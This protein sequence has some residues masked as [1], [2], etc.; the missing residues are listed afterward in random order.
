MHWLVLVADGVEG[1]VPGG[2]HFAGGRVEAGA[3]VLVPGRQVPVVELDG[4]GG[5]PPDLVAG[6]G[7]HL[8]EF[9]DERA[10]FE[11]FSTGSS[12]EGGTGLGLSI[13]RGIARAHGGESG[14]V[15]RPGQ[16]ATFWIRIPR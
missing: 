12:Q 2:E 14:V 3:G 8:A 11:P 10:V 4:L 9:G 15:N 16:G 5:G 13:V 7:D 1:L 6:R